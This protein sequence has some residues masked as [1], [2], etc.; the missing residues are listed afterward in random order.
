MCGLSPSPPAAA[1]TA[2]CSLPTLLHNPP[3][4]WICQPLPCHESSPPSCPFPPLLL[5]W[6]NVSS[7]SPW[8]SYCHTVRFSVSSACFLFLNLLSSFFWLCKEPQCVYLHLHLGQ[9]SPLNHVCQCLITA[10][11]HQ[12][13]SSWRDG[14]FCLCLWIASIGTGPGT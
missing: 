6:M 3:P 4:R 5:V 13:V 12:S 10:L 8:L 7:L 11:P 2:S 9:K 14:W 1:P